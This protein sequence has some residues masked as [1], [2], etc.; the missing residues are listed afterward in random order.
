VVDALEVVEVEDDQREVPVVAV[1]TRDLTGERLVEVAAIVEA[2]QR[3]EVGELPRLAEAPSVLD[4][5]AGS[6]RELLKRRD[7]RPPGAGAGA[8]GCGRGGGVGGGK[9]GS[10]R[11]G[12]A[13]PGRGR[14]TPGG[15]ASSAASSAPYSYDMEPACASRRGGGPSRACRSASS[16]ESPSVAT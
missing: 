3:V 2:G 10:S 11:R 5:R 8:G 4:R 7:L 15:I 1:C 13:P 16:A 9:R 14:A 12:A 6:Q